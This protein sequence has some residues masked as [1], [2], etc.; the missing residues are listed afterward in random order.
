MVAL[1]LAACVSKGDTSVTQAD[2]GQTSTCQSVCDHLSAATFGDCKKWTDHQDCVLECQDHMP[3]A[4]G[5]A[6]AEDAQTCEE[7]RTCDSTYDI[8]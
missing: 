3:T 6:C 1:S 8:F 4:V 7:F 2:G 5:L